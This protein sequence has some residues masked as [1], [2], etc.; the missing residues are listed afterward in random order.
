M[1]N[2][3]EAEKVVKETIEY[4]NQEIKKKKKRYLKIFVAILGII[5]LLTSVYLFVFEYETPVKYS[6]DMVNVIVPED[7][8]LDIKINLP[9]YKETNA[10]LVKIDENSYDLYINITQT[11]STRIFDDNDKSDNMLRVGNGMVVDFQSGLLQ[12]YLPNG[13]PGE[14]IMHIYYIDNLSDKT[15]TMDDSELINYKN[16]ILIWTRE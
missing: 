16:K 9:N 13:N 5:V 10:I 2:R 14:S 3:E 6:K 12:E 1:M 8:G 7:K 15:M 11:I 4:A